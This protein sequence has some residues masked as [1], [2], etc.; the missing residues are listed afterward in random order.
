[1]KP[2]SNPRFCTLQQPLVGGI[3]TPLKNISQLGWLFPIYGQ[4]KKVSNHQSAY[5]ALSKLIQFDPS[6]RGIWSCFSIPD[7]SRESRNGNCWNSDPQGID[8]NH[9]HGLWLCL[10]RGTPKLSIQ[11]G[12]MLNKSLELGAPYFQSNLFW[13]ILSTRAWH[14]LFI[15]PG[16]VDNWEW[17]LWPLPSLGWKL[18]DSFCVR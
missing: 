2:D 6:I 4:I 7:M 15:A 8:R 14:D 16:M 12:K 17:H 18:S 11:V 10:E 1:M 5:I 3:P 13:W 9:Q